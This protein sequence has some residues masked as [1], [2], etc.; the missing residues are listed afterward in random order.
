[1]LVLVAEDAKSELVEAGFVVSHPVNEPPISDVLARKLSTAVEN[2][3]EG[4]W[5]LRRK[6]KERARRSERRTF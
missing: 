3:L 4:L 2:F 6:P 1:M 5:R